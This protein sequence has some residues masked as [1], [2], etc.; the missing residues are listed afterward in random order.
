[1]KKFFLLFVLLLFSKTVYLSASGDVAL[2]VQSLID[3]GLFRNKLQISELSGTLT[4]DEKSKLIEDNK[5]DATFPMYMN[6]VLGFGVGSFLAKDY[7]GGAVHCSID[8]ACNVVMIAMFT[9]YAKSLFDPLSNKGFSEEDADNILK[10][11][12]RYMYAGIATMLVLLV[13]RIAQLVSVT[14]H[15]NKYNRTLSQVLAGTATDK[16]AVN[17]FPILDEKKFGL[18]I[19]FDLLARS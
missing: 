14:V 16:V 9:I 5:I 8:V 1:M 15:V 12:K 18:G 2:K 19:S 7:I 11:M 6:G 3:E 4:V 10:N 17:L 13:N